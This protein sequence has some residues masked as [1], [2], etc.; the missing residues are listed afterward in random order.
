MRVADS[1]MPTLAD[2]HSGAV[3]TVDANSEFIATG[4][5]NGEL[6][7]WSKSCVLISTYIQSDTDCTCVCFSPCH[8]KIL[9]ASF[10]DKILVFDV[11]NLQQPLD[12]YEGNEDEINQIQVNEKEQFMAAC[13]DTGNIKIFSLQ[14]KKT[15][16]TLRY[17]HTN[18]CSTICF[19]PKKPWELFSGGLDCK[20]L[21]WDFS[22]PKCL[23]FHN[24]QEILSITEAETFLL[25]PPFVHHITMAPDGNHLACAL[26]NGIVAVFDS[27]KKYL[28]KVYALQCH[29]RRVSQVC[30][31]SDS[32]LVSGGNDEKII[33]WDLSKLDSSHEHQA[34]I[35][36]AG[37]L[38]GVNQSV[39]DLCRVGVIQHHSEVNWM[40]PLYVN[41]HQYVAVTD[42]TS[43]I[44]LLS[45]PL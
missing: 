13:D 1:K 2:G 5:E 15:Y 22:K 14:D 31:T 29:R 38:A 18:I 44:T 30:F 28:Q 26:E 11:S 12:T 43:A 34:A 16:K 6:C 8:A 39:S 25:N 9:Y 4:G 7:L 36:N 32:I 10:T 40:K 3:L 37:L 20:L 24:M 42:Q 35:G 41:D 23:N 33:I 17:K 27:H 19:R 45:L 21:H